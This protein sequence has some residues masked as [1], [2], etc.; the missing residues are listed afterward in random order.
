MKKASRAEGSRKKKTAS[1]TS[2]GAARDHVTR[3]LARRTAEKAKDPAPRVIVRTPYPTLEETA[4]LL[5]VS[6]A[7]VRSIR[8]VVR[9]ELIRRDPRTGAVEI[10]VPKADGRL[11]LV[12]ASR[13]VSPKP[14]GLASARLT[15][16][17]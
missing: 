15:P 4:A 9:K 5:G 10:L 16:Q 17:R 12:L 3:G 6:A 11:G 2:R 8:A 13:E 14:R 1:A 7:K